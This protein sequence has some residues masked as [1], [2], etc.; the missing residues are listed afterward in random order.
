M[1][2]LARPFPGRVKETFFRKDANGNPLWTDKL[3]YAM[4]QK[5][6]LKKQTPSLLRDL[7]VI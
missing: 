1:A 3:V 2:G 5:T 4:P 6:T 7:R